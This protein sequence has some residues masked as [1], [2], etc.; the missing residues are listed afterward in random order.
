MFL[1]VFDQSFITRIVF[2]KTVLERVYR[3]VLK[4]SLDYGLFKVH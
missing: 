3:K 1:T 2:L 4:R